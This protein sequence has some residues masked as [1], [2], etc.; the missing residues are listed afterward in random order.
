MPTPEGIVMTHE[1]RA[2]MS[3]NVWKILVRTGDAVTEDTALVVLESMK[4]E[5]PVLSEAEGEI[6]ALHVTEGA[7]VSEGDLIAEI[8][9]GR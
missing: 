3:A 2:E 1:V 5:I 7:T 6:T 8:A 9:T 4:M